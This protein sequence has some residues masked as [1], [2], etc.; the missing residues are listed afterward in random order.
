[1]KS[2]LIGIL[3]MIVVS[4][5]AWGVVQTQNT[6]SADAYTTPSVRLD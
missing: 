6:S 2:V 1:M 5:V 4:A 3:L